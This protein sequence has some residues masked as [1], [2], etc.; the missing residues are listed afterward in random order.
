MPYKTIQKGKC[1]SVVN[2]ETGKPASKCTTKTKAAKQQRL[3]YGLESGKWTSYREFVS[4]QMKKRPSDVLA[5][6][7]MKEIAKRW[8]EI[9]GSGEPLLLSPGLGN[10]VADYV[11]S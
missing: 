6:D 8:H 2:T 7:Y 11:S 4:Q 9:K 3:L 1:F 5:K 10:T